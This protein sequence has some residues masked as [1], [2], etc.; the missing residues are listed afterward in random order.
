VEY[1]IRL[2]VLLLSCSLWAGS[3]NYGAIGEKIYHNECASN[4]KYL[5]HWNKGENFPSL[6]IGH[7]IWFPLGV[8]EKFEE[9]FPRF[10]DYYLLTHE[11]IPAWLKSAAPWQ[12]KEEMMADP[13][14]EK[15]RQ[16]LLAT[17]SVQ[18]GFMA[19]R[20]D[21][22]SWEDAHIKKQFAR[23][24]A[25]EEGYYLLIDYLNFKGSGLNPKERYAGTGWGLKQ[26]L[27]CM[28]GKEDARTEFA[29]CAKKVLQLRIKN[30]PPER[31]EKRWLQGWMNR[32]DTY[33]V[34]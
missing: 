26:V 14:I 11:D 10:I 30:S 33:L 9:S 27:S 20:L 1:R 12:N 25:Y 8:K 28:Q 15:L 31:G 21:N 22:I 13:R 3:V 19:Q 7:F 29:N 17:K 34:E 24:A 18:A 4:P 6:G 2:L 16:F 5:V 23:V 32:I